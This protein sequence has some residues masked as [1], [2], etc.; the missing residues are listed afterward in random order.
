[1]S[2]GRGGVQQRRPSDAAKR[3]SILVFAEGS[4]TEPIYLTHWHRLYRERVIVAVDPFHGTPLRIVEEAAAT[5]TRDLREARRGRGDAYDEYWCVFDI[6]EHPRVEEAIKLA[7]DNG[8]NVAVSNPCIELWFLLHFQDQQ[9]SIDRAQAQ[10]KVAEMLGCGKVPT[11]AALGQLA[12]RY[13]QAQVRAQ[14]LD[15]K[16]RRDGSPT[17]SNPSSGVWCLIERIRTP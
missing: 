11:T 12:G 1:V 3:R 8:I 16:H 4:K 9:A 17:R 15:E 10:R 5:R 6:D 13:D 7:A 14:K 2:R